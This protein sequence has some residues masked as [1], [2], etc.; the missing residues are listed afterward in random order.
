MTCFCT[1]RLILVDI[2]SRRELASKNVYNVKGAAM[3][4]QSNGDFLCLRTMV[5]KKTGKKGRKEFT[6]LE[7]FRMREKD[8]PVD[9]L[10]LNDLAVQLH[11]EDGP[12]TCTAKT[13]NPKDRCYM[14]HAVKRAFPFAAP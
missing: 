13:L 8:I 4:W 12:S 9:N 7:I 14:Q 10:Q 11:W 1:G 6:Q 3:H 5:F 2:P